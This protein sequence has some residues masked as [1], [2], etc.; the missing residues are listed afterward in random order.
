MHHRKAIRLGFRVAES[1]ALFG[2]NI[3]SAMIVIS[4]HQYIM[5]DKKSQYLHV[6]N[7]SKE[8][9]DLAV[10]PYDYFV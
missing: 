3:F 2:Y 5:D 8:R 6:K 10:S 4:L 7:I 9:A 1:S